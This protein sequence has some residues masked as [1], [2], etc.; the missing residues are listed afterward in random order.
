MKNLNTINFI[1]G[2]I[3]GTIATHMWSYDKFLYYTCLTPII[4]IW[5]LLININMEMK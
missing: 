4:I 2:I 5:Y 1:S 3:F